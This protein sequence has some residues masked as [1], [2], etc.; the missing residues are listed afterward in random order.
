VDLRERNQSERDTSQRCVIAIL[1]GPFIDDWEFQTRL[2]IDRPTLSTILAAQGRLDDW[3]KV[4]RIE[5]LN[6]AAS[7]IPSL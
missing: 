3:A 1:E 5:L 2:G 4:E 7:F 6:E